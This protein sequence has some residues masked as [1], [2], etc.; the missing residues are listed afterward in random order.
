M[1]EVDT[2][3]PIDEY[4]S[5][6]D[7][8]TSDYD[9]QVELSEEWISNGS[10]EPSENGSARGMSIRNTFGTY[11]HKIETI[12]EEP[13]TSTVRIVLGETDAHNT[14]E[15]KKRLDENRSAKDL[16]SPCNLENLFNDDSIK[17]LY[18]R[19]N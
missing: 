13:E 6:Y 18:Y 11:G 12:P 8:V 16:F 14:P 9:W 2:S 7:Q 10:S 19:C 3:P 17:Y 5:A 1:D 4:V 15:W